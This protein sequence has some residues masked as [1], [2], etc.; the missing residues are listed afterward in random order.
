MYGVIV[1]KVEA[2]R[3]GVR[4]D[5]TDVAM[6]R[7]YE[8]WLKQ[9]EWQARSEMLPLIVGVE[10]ER[11]TEYLSEHHLVEEER[12]L[13]DLVVSGIGIASDDVALP[14][15][16]A[17]EWFRGNGVELPDS[18]IRLYDFI[19]QTILPPA[20]TAA[21]NHGDSKGQSG[22][23]AGEKEIVLGAALSLVSRQPHRCRDEHGFVDGAIVSKLILETAV[24][25]FPSTAP[26]MTQ[27]Q[28]A[29][30]IDKWLERGAP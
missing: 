5:T 18:F 10:P 11:W 29:E 6:Q 24:R 7:L 14:V 15:S 27:V 8:R 12:T 16:T 22:E 30:L 2:L 28:M 21:V 23:P 17:Y 25:W 9:A 13:W 3:A 1:Q 26:S 19:C 20:T 4:H